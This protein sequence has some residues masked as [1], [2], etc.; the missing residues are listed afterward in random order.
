V[1]VG[2][3]SMERFEDDAELMQA[4]EDAAELLLPVAAATEWPCALEVAA[5]LTAIRDTFD[6]ARVVH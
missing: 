6:P 3:K 4:L 5:W 2:G 1:V